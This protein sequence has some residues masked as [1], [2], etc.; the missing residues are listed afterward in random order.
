L[1]S[2]ISI[3]SNS[4]L[5]L[6]AHAPP[7]LPGP[8]VSR[9]SQVADLDEARYVHGISFSSMLHWWRRR[10]LAFDTLPATASASVA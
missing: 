9:P 4:S 5:L 6:W 2:P 8:L 3:F 1:F 10:C 7:K